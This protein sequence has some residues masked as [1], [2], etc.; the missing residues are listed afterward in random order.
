MLPFTGRLLFLSCTPETNTD[1]DVD[2]CVDS[3]AKPSSSS[4]TADMGTQNPT[5][6]D[7]TMEVESLKKREVVPLTV[8]TSPSTKTA[9]AASGISVTTPPAPPKVSSIK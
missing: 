3:G 2:H 9:A 8:N 5:D 6:V 4:T 1:K 7:E